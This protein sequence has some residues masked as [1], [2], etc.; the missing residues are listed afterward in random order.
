M[1]VA[2]SKNAIDLGIV[3]N[4]PDAMLAFYR[5]LLG[6]EEEASTPFPIGGK[7]YRLWCGESLIKIVAPEP[8]APAGPVPG[9]I[10]AATGYRYWTM[11]VTNLEA[12]MAKCEA[13]E[14]NVVVPVSNPRPGVMI[15]IVEDPDGN[16]VE[17]VTYE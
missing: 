2:L 14:V 6:F 17:F 1:T 13:A 3:T 5:D 11:R 12:I 7:M 9:A 15:G 8:A 4:N 10:A 16:W